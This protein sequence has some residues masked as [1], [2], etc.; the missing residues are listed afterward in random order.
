M[1]QQLLDYCIMFKEHA[2][3][4]SYDDMSMCGSCTKFPWLDLRVLVEY[5]CLVLDV[6]WDI[7]K[8]SC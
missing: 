3:I 7:M 2:W 6:T 5:Y 1:Y 4:Y 8:V